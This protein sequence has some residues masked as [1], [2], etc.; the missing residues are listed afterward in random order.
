MLGAR[1][2]EGYRYTLTG[3]RSPDDH[4]GTCIELCGKKPAIPIRCTCDEGP[5][6]YLQERP[7]HSAVSAQ[8]TV[9][10]TR[11]K[12]VVMLSHAA[13][14]IMCVYVRACVCRSRPIH[15]E[16]TLNFIVVFRL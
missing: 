11:P 8:T 3:E 6:W 1:S 16:T 14:A 10:Q 5:P 7:L 9:Q 12:R 13:C 4:D 2:G 15:A